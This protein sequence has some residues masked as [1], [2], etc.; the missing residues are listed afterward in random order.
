MG[1]PPPQ[2][3]LP[4]PLEAG[5]LRLNAAGIL[6]V[7]LAPG[8]EGAPVGGLVP[9]ALKAGPGDDGDKDA[10]R[11]GVGEVGPILGGKVL[12]YAPT[13]IT[14]PKGTRRI[15]RSQSMGGAKCILSSPY[16]ATV[17]GS[18]T[19]WV[20]GIPAALCNI[21]LKSFFPSFSI[22]CSPLHP[23]HSASLPPLQ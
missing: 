8:L 23:Q 3:G 15:T 21:A 1:A 22:S 13:A 14:L 4:I 2:Y 19:I 16:L 7:E 17:L 10:R 12:P 20:L 9:L 6:G 11:E 18:V 5:S